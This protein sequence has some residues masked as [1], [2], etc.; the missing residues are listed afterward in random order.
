MCYASKDFNENFA[1]VAL[2]LKHLS[3]FL[4][5]YLLNLNRA[6]FF[7]IFFFQ[8]KPS[9]F[10]HAVLSLALSRGWRRREGFSSASVLSWCWSPEVLCSETVMCES[11]GTGCPG[12]HHLPSYG[13]CEGISKHSSGNRSPERLSCGPE[14]LKPHMVPSCQELSNPGTSHGANCARLSS[15]CRG[16]IV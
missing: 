15:Q 5:F 3:S 6:H 9:S 10:L 1:E 4:P 2:C 13:K 14:P 11:H 8:T 7:L 16:G 12:Q